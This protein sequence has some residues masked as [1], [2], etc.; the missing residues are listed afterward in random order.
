MEVVIRGVRGKTTIT[1]TY[2]VNPETG[3]L[4]NPTEETEITRD[5]IPKVIFVGTKEEKS[6]L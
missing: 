1:R 6:H 2:E 4:T 5:M 3:E